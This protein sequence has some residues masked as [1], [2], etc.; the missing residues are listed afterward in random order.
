MDEEAVKNQQREQAAQGF[1]TASL[2]LGIISLFSAFCCC[3]FIFSALGILFALLSK[4]AEKVLR[5]KA[6]TGLLLSIIGMV[7]SVV[8]TIFTLVMPF[9]LIK[10]NPEY[11]KLFIEKYEEQLKENEDM[12]RQ[13]YGDDVF[14]SMSDYMDIFE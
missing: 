5:D 14:D 11:K 1:A 2:V 8:L 6:R 12:I 10:T 4:G 7:V 13:V 3:P 9:V